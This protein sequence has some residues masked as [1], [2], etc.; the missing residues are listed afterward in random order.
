MLQ[1]IKLAFHDADTDTDT[2]SDS[3]DTSM[4]HPYTSD[5]RDFLATILAGKSESVSVSVSA[6]WNA[7]FTAYL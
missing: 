3:P 5:T 1:A 6:P 2:D 7:S 4:L